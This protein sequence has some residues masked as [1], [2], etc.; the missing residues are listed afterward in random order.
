MALRSG[1][2]A[3]PL[4]CPHRAPHSLDHRARAAGATCLLLLVA[5]PILVRRHT[6]V[7]SVEGRV[8]GCRLGAMARRSTGNNRD[9]SRLAGRKDLSMPLAILTRTDLSV[10]RPFLGQAPIASRCDGKMLVP[11]GH[12]LR[13][14]LALRCDGNR[15]D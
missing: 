3:R 8:S 9:L 7:Y 2:M 6:Q 4:A 15:H 11:V 1:E 12:R 13:C 5:V 14:P 10:S